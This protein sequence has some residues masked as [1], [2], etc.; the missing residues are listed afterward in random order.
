MTVDVV[1]RLMQFCIN[2]NQQGYLTPAEFDLVINQAQLD[3]LNYLLGQVQQYQP[4]RPYPRV[5][6]GM[7]ETIRSSL[8]AL[9]DPLTTLTID[10]TGVA[11]YPDD[12]QFTD[13]MLTT[14]MQ[15]VRYVQQ[16]SLFSY[17][18]SVITPVAAHPIYLINSA[19]FQFYPITLGNALLS[20]VHTPRAIVWNF[21]PDANGRPIYTPTGSFD[22]EW[23]DVDCF[24][25]IVRA[26]ALVGLNLQL[27]QVMQYS[28]MIKTQG[29]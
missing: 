21:N 29:T 2:K 19:G 23:Y 5:G 12:F 8:A 14:T 22:P 25:L 24:Q 26:L 27:P 11:A 1:Y 4:G 28:Q 10:G 3:L 6:L 16:D 18:G 20:Y 15:R 13:T 7:S 9:I 17:L